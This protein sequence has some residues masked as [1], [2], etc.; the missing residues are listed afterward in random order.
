MTLDPTVSEDAAA[1]DPI[2]PGIGWWVEA[3]TYFAVI[4]F[5]PWVGLRALVAVAPSVFTDSTVSG[6]AN[7]LLTFVVLLAGVAYLLLSAG[8]AENLAAWRRHGLLPDE[9]RQARQRARGELL[10]PAEARER[11]RERA[12]ATVAR[13][14]DTLDTFDDLEY[15]SADLYY[16]GGRREFAMRC[17]GGDEA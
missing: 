2:E 7:I 3:A 12:R 10:T 11:E 6:W 9:F 1:I 13:L 17:D 16:H 15:A 4:Y 5:A 8:V 14:N